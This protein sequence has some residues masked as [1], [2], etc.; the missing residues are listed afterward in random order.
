MCILKGWKLYLKLLVLD[1]NS[2]L[3]RAFY[4]VKGLATKEGFFTNGIYGFLTTLQ[5]V[6]EETSP[7]AIAIAFD[8]KK[9]TF[10][11]K[12]YEGYK[13]KRKGM[14][15]DLA[16]QLP[17]LKELLGYL[18]LS[19]IE[20]EG[21]EADD[22]LGTLAKK[23]EETGDEC[24]IATGDRDSLQ[25][26]SEN[27][28]VRITATKFGKPEVTL[29]DKDKIFEKYGVTPKQ[30]IDIKAIQGDSS[31]NIPG[32]AGIGEKGANE[33]IRKFKN[34]D[35]IYDNIDKIDIKEGMRKKLKEGK[36]SAYMS[37]ML[38]TV[39]T[40]VPIDTDINL[41]I[42]KECNTEKALNLMNKL[43]FFSLIDKI[44]LRERNDS[45]NKVQSGITYK[46]LRENINLEHLYKKLKQ[47]KS[48]RFL[49]EINSKNVILIGI[50]T[51]SII[52]VISEK[53]SGFVE[54]VK[55]LFEDL[56]IEKQT[57]NVKSLI[58]ALKSLDIN[59]KNIKF[60]TMLAAYLLNPSASDYSLDRL[61]NE[62][63][64]TKTGFEG[65]ENESLLVNLSI[66]NS[67]IDKLKENIEKNGQ[68]KLLY[69]IEIP[70]SKLL[71]E[72]EDLGFGVDAEGIEKYGE[73]LD[74]KIY[75]M[76][77]QIYDY[78]GY[79]FN[80]NSPKQLG[81]ALFEGL[82]LP[83]GKKTKSGYS[84]S[85]E[86][87]EG[88]RYA[89]PVVDD[90]LEYRTL[91]KL[92]STYCDGMIK[93]IEKDGRIHSKFNQVETRTGRISSTEPN[94]QNIPVRTDIGRELRRFF[95]AKEGH[96][97]VD[98]DYS[99]I[100]LRVLAHVAN[101]ENMIEA[102][103][104]NEDIHAITASQVFHIPSEM[105]TP[106]M[107]SR[108]KAVNFG[109][110]Y[111]IS[112]FSLSKD[113]GVT[114]KEAKEYINNY[115]NHYSGVSKYMKEVVEDAEEKGYVET[116]FKRRRYLPE[117]TS[118]NFN[119]RSFGKRVAMNM[120]IQG[121]A[122]DIIK[123]AMLK[124][125]NRLIAENLKSKLILQVHDELIVEAPEDESKK[126][127]AILKVEMEKAVNLK[128]PLI[129]ETSIGKTWYDA[130]V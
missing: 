84:T 82:G 80:I 72:M 95:I 128:V 91:T 56:S 33:L 93:V 4:G 83:V 77:K 113:I 104:N 41:F 109:I 48:V 58:L 1:G 125:E 18:G 71:A 12:A 17:I 66:L 29:Y 108:A 25:L 88:I 130:K 28:S 73:M 110:V 7:N 99:Q 31:D 75:E 54:F 78:V 119:L 74:K 117:I 13:A 63:E 103:E 68:Q 60:D 5:K 123:I 105:L 121:A 35:Y 98:A 61:C 36:E 2:I 53:Q 127:A 97:L 19:I 23:C 64:G 65:E 44:G 94:L 42:P 20:C 89:H 70:L 106:L 6:K 90:I 14:P 52:Y 9:P 122:A 69:D 40:D 129:A 87:L 8:V 112:A 111:G 11:H 26:V 32:V 59:P 120:P 126:V 27:V 114:V 50:I 37:K 67:I 79:E 62:Y 55:K 124:V 46:I 86:V 16:K 24:I 39:R 107:R 118:S 115:L 3:N 22:I 38:G 85:A 101:D 10:R 96:V 47:N 81:S 100:E 49:A 34:L 92:K 45:T 30:L 21:F 15:E 51:N 76:Q 116:M 102:F 43:E 57:H